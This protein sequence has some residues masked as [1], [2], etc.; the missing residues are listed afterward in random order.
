M[1]DGKGHFTD[2]F[3]VHLTV[4]LGRPKRHTKSV[5]FRRIR[6]VDDTQFQE[7]LR[8]HLSSRTAGSSPDEQVTSFNK[9][10]VA[11]LDLHAPIVNKTIVVRPDTEWYNTDLLELKRARRQAE[12][13]M[14][15]TDLTVDKV[16][17]EDRCDIC[18]AANTKAQEVYYNTKIKEN[19]NDKRAQFS[20]TNKLL[21]KETGVKL[22]SHSSK[23][24]LAE[25]FSDYF[26][27]KIYCILNA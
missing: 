2:H 22:P 27:Q 23:E 14:L 3:A 10:L 26:D 15:K 9:A 18:N 6:D 1:G 24:E 12:R 8:K 19:K 20:I 5:S 16:I 4:T 11:V 21:G 13:R 17:F 25:R 7:D